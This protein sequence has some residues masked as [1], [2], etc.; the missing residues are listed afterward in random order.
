MKIPPLLALRA[1]EAVARH[2]SVRKAAEELCVDHTVVSRH[3]RTLQSVLDIP[4]LRSSRRGIT[5]TEAGSEYAASLS[6]AFSRISTATAKV[7]RHRRAGVLSIW[8]V[9]GFA[10]HWLTPR[11]PE[12][13]ALCPGIEL[14]L[15]P[16]DQPP[17]FAAFEAD[18]EIRYGEPL[19]GSRFEVLARPRV[20]PVASGDWIERHPQI[21]VPADL[22]EASLIHEDTQEYWR[23]WFSACGV[24]T[25]DTLTGPRLWHSHLALAA[26]RRGQGVAIANDLIAGEDLRSGQLREVGTSDVVLDPYVLVAQEDRWNEPRLDAF[27][28]WLLKRLSADRASNAL[29]VV[30]LVHQRGP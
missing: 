29:P 30:R 14:T 20:F 15:K 18:A 13:Q 23:A 17:D 8:S 25:P 9:P 6:Q 2:G 1:F 16:T 5:L 12:F 28:K 7:R 24:E 26:A 4:L 10:L 27:R 3:I 21:G 19:D 22:L 11:L